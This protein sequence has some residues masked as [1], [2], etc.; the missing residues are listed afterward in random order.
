MVI[1]RICVNYYKCRKDMI[2]NEYLHSA[3]DVFN[4]F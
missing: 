2:E 3:I 4:W 1:M